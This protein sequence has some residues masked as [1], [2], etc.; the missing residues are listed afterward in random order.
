[1]PGNSSACNHCLLKTG[2]CYP[3]NFRDSRG[4]DISINK[5]PLSVVSLDPS[6]TEIILRIGAGDKLKAVTIPK[7]YPPEAAL[8]PTAGTFNNPDLDRLA[9]LNPDLIFYSNTQKGVL[10][11]F[12]KSRAIL[13]NL[14]NSS[15][16]ESFRQIRLMGEIFS[17]KIEAEGIINEN[18]KY[19][20][21]IKKKTELIYPGKRKRV[22]CIL[23]NKTLM[24]PG[25]NSIQ[26]E[27][28]TLAGGIPLT[29]GREGSYVP[30][31]K[32]ELI[33]FNPHIIYG[34]D[35][36]RGLIN[37]ILS[38]PELRDVEAIKNY[39]V[40]FYPSDLTSRVS[41]NTGYFIEWLSADIY[42]EE[43]AKKENF[44]LPEKVINSKKLEI[45]LSYV[46]DLR[47]DTSNLYDFTNKSLIIEFRSL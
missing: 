46:N 23:G 39:N 3:V 5:E 31:D 35:N 25:D 28:I 15:I 20:E 40:H 26:R 37:K 2:H 32:K 29:I 8:K 42:R 9:E 18:K 24:I 47:I 7:N 33:R 16:E 12:G 44:I 10:E 19:I 27:F 30:I 13:I 4:R 22:L 38:D 21:K 36:D 17:R 14:E 6:I 41:T 43:Y 1:L 45:D 11:R 34:S